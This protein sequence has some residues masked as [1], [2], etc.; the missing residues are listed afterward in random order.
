MLTR[1]PKLNQL[2]DQSN[3]LVKIGNVFVLLKG[4]DVHLVSLVK[5]SLLT[6]IIID[7]EGRVL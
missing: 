4:Q 2:F 7:R 6:D 5:F 3:R 1:Y